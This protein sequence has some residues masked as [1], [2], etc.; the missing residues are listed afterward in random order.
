M[1]PAQPLWPHLV[2]LPSSKL[3]R[4][5][6]LESWWV[7][8]LSSTSRMTAP[9]A[10]YST[11]SA[12]AS[13]VFDF[14]PQPWNGK[15]CWT[16]TAGPLGAATGADR[17]AAALAALLATP[18]ACRTSCRRARGTVL[19]VGRAR[20]SSC[21][22]TR[23]TACPADHYK[24]ETPAPEGVTTWQLN[25]CRS[26]AAPASSPLKLKRAR[27]PATVLMPLKGMPDTKLPV[28]FRPYREP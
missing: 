24:T 21:R 9:Q 4:T 25:M 10:A 11:K 15:W 26:I 18:S 20:R 2:E 23:G 7:C 12:K 8:C 19:N 6:Q 13:T 14:Q 3:R 28:E 1:A 22:H 17:A 16:R 27:S 5:S